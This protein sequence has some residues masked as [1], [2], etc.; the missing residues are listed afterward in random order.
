MYM[1]YTLDDYKARSNFAVALSQFIMDQNKAKLE[2][3][4]K[5]VKR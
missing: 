1:L 5:I 4:E 2:I 3:N